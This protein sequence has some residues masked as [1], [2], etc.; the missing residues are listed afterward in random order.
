M[1]RDQLRIVGQSVG[2]QGATWFDTQNP[3]TAQAW[4]EIPQR[5]LRDVDAAAATPA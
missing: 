5:D 1:K 4:A 2:P 3:R